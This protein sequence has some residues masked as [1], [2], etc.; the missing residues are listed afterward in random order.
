MQKQGLYSD[1]FVKCAPK[2]VLFR[3]FLVRKLPV[4]VG[5]FET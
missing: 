4:I 1:Y 2:R 3:T 5:R